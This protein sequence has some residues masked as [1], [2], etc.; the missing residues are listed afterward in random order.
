M[1]HLLP[2]LSAHGPAGTPQRTGFEEGDILAVA[3]TEL[4]WGS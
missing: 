3:R 4:L 1:G 2:H